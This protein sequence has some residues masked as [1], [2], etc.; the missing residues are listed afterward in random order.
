[1]SDQGGAAGKFNISF[2]A[3]TNSQ[4]V[5]GDYNHVTQTVG[6]TPDEVAALRG[7]FEDL[8]TA[9]AAEVPPERREE[10]AASAA[11]LE[12]A[13]VAKEPDSGRVRKVLRWFRD[14]APQIAGTVA[15]VVVNPLVGKVIE[16]AGEAVAERVREAV[17]DA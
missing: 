2:G 13:L 9:I 11:E 1:M 14:N 8:R 5:A 15:A 7:V 16:G 4:I 3:V 12:A 6:L 10:A 17:E